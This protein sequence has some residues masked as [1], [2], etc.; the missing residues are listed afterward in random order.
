MLY[1][2]NC[3]PHSLHVDHPGSTDHVTLLDAKVILLLWDRVK[4]PEILA[5]SSSSSSEQRRARQFPQTS[6]IVRLRLFSTH[7][8]GRQLL[9]G[10]VKKRGSLDLTGNPAIRVTRFGCGSITSFGAF[11]FLRVPSF[12]RAV[13]FN[14]PRPQPQLR[15]QLAAPPRGH[16]PYSRRSAPSSFP[17]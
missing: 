9:P 15:S 7:D 8:S 17:S 16:I 2:R 11:F 5:S 10:V 12:L 14:Q 6:S 4:D 1:R 13:N 3:L